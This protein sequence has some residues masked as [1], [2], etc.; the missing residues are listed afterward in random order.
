MLLSLL[1]FAGC[2]KRG[3]PGSPGY[4][5]PKEELVTIVVAEDFFVQE[6]NRRTVTRQAF[7]IIE[8]EDLKRY[9]LP[10]K[11]GSVG[12]TFIADISLLDRVEP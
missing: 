7:T 1:V 4:I 12:D 6:V 11:V 2:D 10:G 3:T 8:S 5:P 9:V